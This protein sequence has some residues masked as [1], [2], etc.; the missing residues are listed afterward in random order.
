MI[1][2]ALEYVY[3]VQKYNI[4]VTSRRLLQTSSIFIAALL[5]DDDSRLVP[6]KKILEQV[7]FFVH[8]TKRNSAQVLLH[9]GK[10]I[11]CCILLIVE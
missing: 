1:L 9:S 5:L 3:N 8:G 7:I 10:N 11:D 2:L 6:T 4:L